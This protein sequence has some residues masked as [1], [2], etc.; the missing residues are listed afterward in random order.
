M[1]TS[2]NRIKETEDFLS[3]VMEPQDKLLFRARLLLDPVLRINTALQKQAYALIRSYGR[4]KL[5]REIGEAH[6]NI[7]TDP[8]KAKYRRDIYRMFI[9]T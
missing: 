4:K 1:R 6:Q 5:R 3:G 9:D 7:F 8:A 2:L